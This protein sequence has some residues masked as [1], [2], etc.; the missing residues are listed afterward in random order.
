M[1]IQA[2]L[3]EPED[4]VNGD[5][6]ATLL[7]IQ[8]VLYSTEEGFEAPPEEGDLLED[9]LV[10]EDEHVL[11]QQAAGLH[12]EGEHADLDLQEQHMIGAPTGAHKV[13]EVDETF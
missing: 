13:S 1:L 2:R 7:N 6:K 10:G 8:E 4:K 5:E 3:A 11:A 12:L 9:Q